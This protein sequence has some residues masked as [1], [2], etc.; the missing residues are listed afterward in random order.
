[1]HLLAGLDTLRLHPAGLLATSLEE[2]VALSADFEQVFQGSGWALRATQRRELLLEGPPAESITSQDPARFLGRAV[3]EGVPQGVGAAALRRL[4]SEI[5]MWLHEHPLNLRRMAAGALPING[6]WL[7]GGGSAASPRVRQ[8]PPLFGEDLAAEALWQ[9]AGQSIQPLP[10]SWAA[11]PDTRERGAVLIVPVPSGAGPDGLLGLEQQ[12]IAPL[13][14]HALQGGGATL[15]CANK[16]F[17]LG[18]GARWKLWRRE[19]AWWEALS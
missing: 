15:L 5:E 10:A 7:W 4:M 1:V 14:A 13:L 17:T 18:G 19:Q 12:W 3:R 11:L 9:L 16:R 2:Q 8:L 6:L